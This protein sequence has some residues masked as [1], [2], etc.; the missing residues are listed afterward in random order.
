MNE[1]FSDVTVDEAV[2][3]TVFELIKKAQSGDAVAFEELVSSHYDTIYQI[4]YSWLADSQDAQDVAQEVC[5]K[6]GKSIQNFKF[7]SKFSTWLYRV[8]LNTAKDYSIKRKKHDSIEELS[9]ADNLEIESRGGDEE[10]QL[11]KEEYEELWLLVRQL[12]TKQTDSVL[13]VYSQG[14]N[15][16]QAAEVMQCAEATVSWYIH[17]AK[18]KLKK[19]IEK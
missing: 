2:F 8:T 7:K 19:L 15:H 18:K 9:S 12:P 10:S 1:T 4:A 14:M 13:L 16:A 3:D 5:V 17:Q 6:L 11:H